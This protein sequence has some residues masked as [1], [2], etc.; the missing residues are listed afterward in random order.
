MR[1]TSLIILLLITKILFCQNNFIGKYT[2]IYRDDTIPGEH[3]EAIYYTTINIQKNNKF[4][5]C[6]QLNATGSKKE[7][8]ETVNGNWK[9]SG[10]TIIF[11]PQFEQKEPQIKYL[12]TSK[13]DV[14]TIIAKNSKGKQVKMTAIAVD[15]LSEDGKTGFRKPYGQI[16]I[17]EINILHPAYTA[18]HFRPKGYCKDFTGCEISIS[19]E[20]I[21]KGTSIIFTYTNTNLENEVNNTKY[22][23]RDNFLHEL[24][25]TKDIPNGW[26]DNFKKITPP[27]TN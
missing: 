22:I 9:L 4:T 7:L 19:L 1:T 27:N 12:E 2:D 17:K 6:Y 14:I 8:Q 26:T 11:N 10:D 25:K 5:Y 20:G 16:N 15:S 24:P 23:L 3:S 18:I 21:K 13:K